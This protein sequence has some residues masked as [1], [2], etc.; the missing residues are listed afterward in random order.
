MRNKFTL[1]RLAK[2]LGVVGL[3]VAREDGSIVATEGAGATLNGSAP[4]PLIADGESL[5]ELRI[6]AME[7]GG[8]LSPHD[9]DLLR[10]SAEFVAAALRVGLRED[11]QVD[12]L[13]GLVRERAAVASQ[14]STLHVALLQHGDPPDQ[15]RVFALGPLRVE[16]AGQPIER[17]G[18]DKAGSRQAEGLFAFLLDRGDHGVAK[19]EVLEL[20]WPDTDIERADLAFHRT[21]VGLRKTLDPARDG[22]SSQA[23]RFRNDRYRLDPN[24]VAWSDVAAFL[25]HLDAAGLVLDA[26]ERLDILEEARRLYRGDYMD[27]CPFFGDSVEA[28]GERDRLRTRAIDLRVAIGEAYEA[29]GDRLSAA[30]AFREAVRDAPDGCPPAEAGL[31][32]LQMRSGAA[33]P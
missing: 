2:T 15:L 28:E 7:S 6:G 19:D 9:E 5:G 26:R 33:A 12:R 20:I 32:R 29:L 21:M 24:I 1:A 27:D 10:M 13:A 25:G 16:R 3:V 4:I 14:A 18:G 23:I 17:W 11:E 8:T 31:V 30:A 22:R